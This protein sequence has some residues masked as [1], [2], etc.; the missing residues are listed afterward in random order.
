MLSAVASTLG[1]YEQQIRNAAAQPRQT[2]SRQD[3]DGSGRQIGAFGEKLMSVAEDG[4]FKNLSSD[5]LKDMEKDLE[6]GNMLKQAVDSSKD[7][8]RQDSIEK[9]KKRIAELKERLK[10]ATPQQAKALLRELK[11]ITK[12]F[13]TAAQSLSDSGGSAGQL[14]GAN[15]M[16]A[17]SQISA[18]S[19]T[20][21]L[22]IQST[23]AVLQ[24]TPEAQEDGSLEA[25]IETLLGHDLDP[26][27]L[28]VLAAGFAQL[29][30]LAGKASDRNSSNDEDGNGEKSANEDGSGEDGANSAGEN[31]EVIAATIA[32]REVIAAYTSTSKSLTKKEA[33]STGYDGTATRRAQADELRK[34]AKEIKA[35]ADQIKTLMKKDDK[36]QKDDMKKAMS[37]LQKGNDALDKFALQ[38]D[39]VASTA[40]SS[41][42]TAVQVEQTAAVYSSLSIEVSVPANPVA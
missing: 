41:S 19:Q 26:A 17:S 25:A 36:D 8:Q 18:A 29:E 12:E 23:D 3:D 28:E 27:D 42:V 35:V 30:E 40:S 37:D 31:Q 11:Q 16:T 24:A 33:T 15:A 4:P 9:I 1:R 14:T 7:N 22:N 34:I 13:K 10:F 21:A 39:S 38:P 5:F 32:V 6:V 2:S 20:E